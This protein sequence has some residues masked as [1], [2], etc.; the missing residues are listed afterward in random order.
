MLILFCLKYVNKA[1]V[2]RIQWYEH[3]KSK[4]ENLQSTCMFV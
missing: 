4:T 1:K 3:R 2:E